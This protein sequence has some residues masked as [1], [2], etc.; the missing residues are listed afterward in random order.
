MSQSL[1]HRIRI[2]V[3]ETDQYEGIP[4]YKWLIKTSHQHGLA[5]ATAIRAMEGFGTDGQLH[6]TKI[7][8]LATDLP[9]IIEIVDT[10]DKTEVFIDAI[11]LATRTVLVTSEPVSVR[12]SGD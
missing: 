9:V 1:A 6:A 5:G 11:A 2:Y 12:S 4:L 10:P 7:F 3:G 8:R